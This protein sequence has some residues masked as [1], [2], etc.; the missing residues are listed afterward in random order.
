[1][2]GAAI[3]TFLLSINTLLLV[4]ALVLLLMLPTKP[5]HCYSSPETVRVAQIPE[6]APLALLLV[7]AVPLIALRT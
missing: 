3:R 2:R 1:M 5:A 4:V 7:A 6:P